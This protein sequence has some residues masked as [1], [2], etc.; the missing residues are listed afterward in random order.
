MKIRYPTPGSSAANLY[1]QID[2]LNWL[3]GEKLEGFCH[4]SFH[5]GPCELGLRITFSVRR[6]APADRPL[7]FWHIAADK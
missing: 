3:Q 6:L 5:R 2:E 1:L 4:Q 7:P